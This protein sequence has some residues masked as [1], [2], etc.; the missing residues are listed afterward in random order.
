MTTY[1]ATCDRV[2][3]DT[4]AAS[5]DRISDNV[6]LVAR[7]SGEFKLDVYLA[8]EKAVE[9]AR[10]IL[11][12]AGDPV[13]TDGRP[14]RVGDRVEITKYREWTSELEGKTGTLLEIDTDCI[15]YRVQFDNSDDW[16]WAAEVRRIPDANTTSPDPAETQR[17]SFV[18]DAKRLLDGTTHDGA[19]IVR[20]AAF[21]AGN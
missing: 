8:P 21:L 17:E 11:H 5:R 6:R 1:T 14:L 13:A 19:D 9:L 16:E 18:M 4:I 7:Q 2:P 10:G 20:V 12:L 15:P 3:Y